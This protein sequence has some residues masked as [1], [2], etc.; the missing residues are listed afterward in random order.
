MMHP[1]LTMSH[2][3][4]TV[5][6]LGRTQGNMSSVERQKVAEAGMGDSLP[7]RWAKIASVVT[8]YW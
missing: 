4:E 5:S 2:T 1:R 8:L 7:T 6:E 3:K